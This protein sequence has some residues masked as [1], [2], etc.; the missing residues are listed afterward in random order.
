MGLT[1]VAPGHI[2]Q[3]RDRHLPTGFLQRL[4]HNDVNATFR[5][6]QQIA[7][8]TEEALG[9]I[10]RSKNQLLDAHNA[11]VVVID[12]QINRISVLENQRNVDVAAI[13]QTAG[14]VDGHTHRIDALN[15]ETNGLRGRVQQLEATRE[16]DRQTSVQ[17]V[18]IVDQHSQKIL[19]ALQKIEMLQEAR[20]NTTHRFTDMTMNNQEMAEKIQTL[21]AN[22]EDL[23]AMVISAERRLDQMAQTIQ[24]LTATVALLTNRP[25]S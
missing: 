3:V 7:K 25:N 13:N 2:P 14:V 24:Q 4:I 18:A 20:E 12:N 15:L 10:T 21:F 19:E 16:M 17:T 1:S 9:V 11:T 23:T 6:L 5:Y 22:R 8:A